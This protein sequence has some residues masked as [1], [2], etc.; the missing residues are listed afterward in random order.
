[1]LASLSYGSEREPIVIGKPNP[2]VTDLILEQ[3]TFK[4]SKCLIIGDRLDSDILLGNN[5]EIDTLLVMTGV[6]NEKLLQ[7]TLT[8]KGGIRP[9]HIVKNLK[10]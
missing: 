2:F 5:A 9:V 7:D 10:L 6:T 1:M 3:H 4:K 8:K